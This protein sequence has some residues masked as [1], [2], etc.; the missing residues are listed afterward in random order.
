MRAVFPEVHA[1]IGHILQGD[2]IIFR[3][4]FAQHPQFI[5]RQADPGRV[6]GVRIDDGADTA[7]THEFF[8]PF[9]ESLSPI[10]IYIEHPRLETEHISLHVM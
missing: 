5:L 9:S 8:Q 2:D 3:A 4:Q 1:H 10:V 6:V 7:V